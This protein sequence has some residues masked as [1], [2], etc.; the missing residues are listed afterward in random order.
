MDDVGRAMAR[1]GEALT[2]RGAAL[3][4]LADSAPDGA[5]AALAAASDEWRAAGDATAAE[6][7][8]VLRAAEIVGQTT[9]GGRRPAEA[10]R[11][12]VFAV[13][14]EGEGLVTAA[15][16]LET[17]ARALTKSADG[18]RPLVPG[19]EMAGLEAAAREL[20]AVA[21]QARRAGAAMV[22]QAQ[23]YRQALGERT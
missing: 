10:S 15:T 22:A 23:R 5:R 3:L 4:A 20:V 2:A 1:A 13:E 21:G 9:A 18:V 19:A 17:R 16:R 8:R 7:A 6:A 14:A 12:Y 11:V